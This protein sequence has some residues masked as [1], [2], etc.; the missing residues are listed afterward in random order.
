MQWNMPNCVVIIFGYAVIQR[1]YEHMQ[2]QDDQWNV[3]NFCCSQ[4]SDL[5]LDLSDFPF[6][7]K[8]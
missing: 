1:N 2:K 4:F 6:L 8:A 5:S 3:N 7:K